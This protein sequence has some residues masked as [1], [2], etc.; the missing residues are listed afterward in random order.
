MVERKFDAAAHVDHM[1]P[2]V[3]IEIVPEWRNG[4]IV[5]LETAARMAEL[6]LNFP[7]DDHVEIANV[8]EAGK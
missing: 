8:F 4:V 1:A 3:G 5:N 7:L 6:V 2:V